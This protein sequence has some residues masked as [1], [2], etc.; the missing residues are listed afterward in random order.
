MFARA[1]QMQPKVCTKPYFFAKECMKE[2]SE[3]KPFDPSI[4][5]DQ[6]SVRTSLIL[7]LQIMIRR[8]EGA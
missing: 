2:A 6:L 3:R 5:A 8:H 1:A 7:W 4:S